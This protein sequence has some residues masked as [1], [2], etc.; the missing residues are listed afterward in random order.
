WQR[1]WIKG[2]VLAEQLRYWRSQLEG[3]AELALPVDRG[4]PAVASHRGGKVEV[5]IEE[6]VSLGLKQVSRREGVTVF[7]AL[8]AAFKVVLGRWAGQDDVVVGSSVAG[9]NR[10]EAEGLI[11]FFVNQLVLRTELSGEPTLREVLR[12]VREVT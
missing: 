3:A 4:R 1:G 2:E 12:R 11:G 6:E 5:R 10:M 8:L 7:M 9:R